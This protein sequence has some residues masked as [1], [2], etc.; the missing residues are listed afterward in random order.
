MIPKEVTVSWG[1][2]VD[3]VR[4]QNL[5]PYLSMKVELEEGDNVDTVFAQVQDQLRLAVAAQCAGLA[6]QHITR[7]ASLIGTLRN[8]KALNQF[9]YNDVPFYPWL[10]IVA[11]EMASDVRLTAADLCAPIVASRNNLPA[12]PA[13]PPAPEG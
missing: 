4:Y 6:K 3:V 5:N 8:D 10:C 13:D 11:P 2:K 9:L 7:R 1:A 12:S